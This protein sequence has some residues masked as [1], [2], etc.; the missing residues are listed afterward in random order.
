[1]SRETNKL[2]NRVGL[3]H[4]SAPLN[5]SFAQ[6]LGFP[7]LQDSTSYLWSI[8]AYSSNLE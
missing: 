7:P 5:G 4:N 1:M 3:F 6:G 2:K 8:V